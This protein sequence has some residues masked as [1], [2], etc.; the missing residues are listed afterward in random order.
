MSIQFEILPHTADIR[1][2]AFGKT[3]QELFKNMMLGMFSEYVPDKKKKQVG[4]DFS[5]SSPDL[6]ALLVDFLSEALRLSDTHNEVYNNVL[7]K[8][9]TDTD[10]TGQL[11]GY[12][13][14]GV[15]GEEIKAV[16]YHDTKLEQRQ[17]GS[18]QAEVIF[19]I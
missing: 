15:D 13:L 2:R 17:D 7:F 5:V 19:D 8:A 14:K 16:T 4:R 18:W 10:C 9:F 11:F 1:I 3:R 6:S 12:A